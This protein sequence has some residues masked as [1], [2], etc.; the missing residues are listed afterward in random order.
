MVNLPSEALVARHLPKRVGRLRRVRPGTN[1]V[2]GCFAFHRITGYAVAVARS[3]KGRP[4]LSDLLGRVRSPGR[5]TAGCFTAGCMCN[6][7]AHPPGPATP[8]SCASFARRPSLPDLRITGYAVFLCKQYDA[9]TRTRRSRP[10]RVCNHV[11]I[12]LVPSEQVVRP[13]EQVVRP[14]EQVVRPSEQVVRPS[15]Q[16]VR[17]SDHIHILC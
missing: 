11:V 2:P 9:C 6:R 7:V 1:K 16:V 17:P 15:E 4:N 5:E 13:S 8:C 10:R 12:V 3:T 14:S